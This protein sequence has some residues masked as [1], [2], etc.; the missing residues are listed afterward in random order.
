MAD[1]WTLLLHRLVS[2][3]AAISVVKA[4]GLIGLYGSLIY[5]LYG[6]CHGSVWDSGSCL[7]LKE[8]GGKLLKLFNTRTES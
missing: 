7:L 5:S 6:F 8:G 4:P 1:K 2:N 3:I